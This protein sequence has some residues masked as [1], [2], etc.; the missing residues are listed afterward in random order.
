[1]RV[2]IYDNEVLLRFCDRPYSEP[3]NSSDL[4]SYVV[5]DQYTPIWKIPSLAK[6]YVDLNMNMKASLNAYVKLN[7]GRDPAQIW[8]D[9]EESI[10]TVY[11]NNEANMLEMASAYPN[12]RF[13]N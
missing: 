4:D 8:S 2:Y 5:G 13:D 3:F 1:M 9:I 10:K 12:I 7:L 6:Y 11:Y